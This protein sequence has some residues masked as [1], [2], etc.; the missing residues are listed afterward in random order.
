MSHSNPLS[1]PFL[2][3]GFE[4]RTTPMLCPE[5]FVERLNNAVKIANGYYNF[6]TIKRRLERWCR[7]E[8]LPTGD[9]LHRVMLEIVKCERH[10]SH[11]GSGS[12]GMLGHYGPWDTRHL[13]WIDMEHLPCRERLVLGLM[14][15][16]FDYGKVYTSSYLSQRTSLTEPRLIQALHQL[17]AEKLIMFYEVRGQIIYR[18]SYTL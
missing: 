8:D 13:R 18:P 3:P 10:A 7:G 1:N 6:C 11:S 17:N 4:L 5:N 2:Q 14:D 12:T 9:Q 15:A 16:M